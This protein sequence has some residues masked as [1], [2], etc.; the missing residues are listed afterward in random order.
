M[1]LPPEWVLTGH[2]TRTSIFVLVIPHGKW[3]NEYYLFYTSVTW[4]WSSLDLSM[5]NSSTLMCLSQQGWRSYNKLPEV[6]H[7]LPTTPSTILL[8]C[9]V[10]W[11]SILTPF[12]IWIA[13][14]PQYALNRNKFISKPVFIF[15]LLISTS[16]RTITPTHSSSQPLIFHS[17]YPTLPPTV[18][19]IFSPVLSVSFLFLLPRINHIIS[20]QLIQ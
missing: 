17:P 18:Q 13:T 8:L 2:T 16:H 5:K 10:T 14:R 19:P 11:M 9:S 4:A 12:E 20:L 6:T 3:I 7:P 1:S 15:P